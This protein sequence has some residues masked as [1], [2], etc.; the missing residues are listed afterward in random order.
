MSGQQKPALQGTKNNLE[1]RSRILPEIN[2][3][4]EAH[5]I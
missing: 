5:A 1:N 2:P 3:H 4:R